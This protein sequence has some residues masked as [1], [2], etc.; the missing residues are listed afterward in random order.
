MAAGPSGLYS[1]YAV[2]L[3]TQG[4]V[5]V[6]DYQNSR[7]LQ[8]PTASAAGATSGMSA[9]SVYGQT[10]FASSGPNRGTGADLASASSMNLPEGLAVDA[11][12]NLYVGDSLNNRVLL[13]S[14]GQASGAQVATRVYGQSY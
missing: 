7:V 5:Y 11:R 3:D 10:D 14:P 6:A 12:G 4:N 1:P 13:F 2:A 8:F 9:V